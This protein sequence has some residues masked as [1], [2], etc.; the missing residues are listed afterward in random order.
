MM[1]NVIFICGKV[2]TIPCGILRGFLM[3]HRTTVIGYRKVD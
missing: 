2:E 1:Y 3:T